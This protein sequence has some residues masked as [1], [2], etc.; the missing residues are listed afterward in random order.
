M[1]NATNQTSALSLEELEAQGD[2]AA[3]YI[4]EFLDL[5]DLDGD[6]DLEV[7]NNRAYVSINGGG[8]DLEKLAN[9]E[10][11]Q[12]LQELTRLA[13][14]RKTGDFSGL[15]LDVAGSREARETELR[16]LADHAIAQVAAGKDEVAMDP[17]SSYERK[18]V[19]DYV[20]ERGYHS[21]SHG[22]GRGRR[23]VISAA[24]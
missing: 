18:L 17:L 11:V 20:A 6:L 24:A 23:L 12:A 4:E 16:E 1:T 7:K 22:E 5:A 3:D 21:E 13:V 9:S 10:V 2:H 8:A 19:H 15:I 14:Q